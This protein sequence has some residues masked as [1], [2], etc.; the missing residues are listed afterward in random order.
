MGWEFHFWGSKMP[1]EASSL[2][3]S[4]LPCY[5]SRLPSQFWS[6][7]RNLKILAPSRPPKPSISV[8]K[9]VVFEVFTV[10]CSNGLLDLSSRLLEL[11]GPLF[12]S[13]SGRGRLTA[14]FRATCAQV[15]FRL[16]NGAPEAP[17][18]DTKTTANLPQIAPKG[19]KLRVHR[20]TPY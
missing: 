20:A 6:L 2:L 3:T 12:V 7:D 5:F 14:S 9:V 15:R 19:P 18:N 17:P 8:E 10:L 11:L 1:S 13:K 4:K 16:P